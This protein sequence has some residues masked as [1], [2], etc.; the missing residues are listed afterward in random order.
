MCIILNEKRRAA[1]GGDCEG[2]ASDPERT[3]FPEKRDKFLKYRTEMKR[4]EEKKEERREEETRPRCDSR[5]IEGTYL[6]ILVRRYGLTHPPP[7]IFD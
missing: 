5:L 6:A 1:P 3:S 7:T 2:T 4:G